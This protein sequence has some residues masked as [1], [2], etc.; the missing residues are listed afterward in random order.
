[1]SLYVTNILILVKIKSVFLL[2][3]LEENLF[4]CLFQLLEAP[5][6]SW[7]IAISSTLKAHS[8][9]ICFHH[10]IFYLPLTLTSLL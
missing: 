2:E 4:A 10:H 9:N 8:S 6:N 5:Y 3:A 1:M 7:L